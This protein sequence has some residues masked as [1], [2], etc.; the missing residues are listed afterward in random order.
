MVAGIGR[1][2]RATH[3]W[4]TGVPRRRSPAH[5]AEVP[6]DAGGKLQSGCG[7]QLYL[8]SSTHHVEAVV[9]SQKVGKIGHG[10]FVQPVSR[11]VD[12]ALLDEPRTHWS[13]RLRA[14][15]T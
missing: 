7:S 3:V 13:D 2:T 4:R 5:P 6:R 8:S 1:R 14:G 11:T 9:T 12:Q 15:T 10:E